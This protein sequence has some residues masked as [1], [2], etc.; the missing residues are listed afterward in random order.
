[1]TQQAK[2]KLR[3]VQGPA[4]HT[5]QHSKSPIIMVMPTGG[6]KSMLFMLPAYIKPSRTTVVV[7][8]LIAL[9]QDFQ[10]RCQQLNISYTVWERRR[11]PDEASIVLVTPES[12]ITPEFHS[13]LN[14]LRI[15]RRLDRIV[16]DECYIMLPRSADFRPAMRRLGKLIQAQTQL[17]FLTAT[18]PPTLEQALFKQIGHTR[19]VVRLFRAPTTRSNI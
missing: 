3:G 18:L 5:I 4:L 9:R 19:E 1:M 7:I 16:I 8:P 10:Q 15:V 12:A 2:L 6:G 13:F 11:P 17:V 14:Q